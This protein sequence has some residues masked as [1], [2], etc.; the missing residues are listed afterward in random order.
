MNM[1]K[2]APED[3]KRQIFQELKELKDQKTNEALQ[4]CTTEAQVDE[5]GR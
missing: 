1:Q 5:M 4:L 3:Y 2:V